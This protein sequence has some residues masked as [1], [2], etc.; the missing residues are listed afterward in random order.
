[1][2]S[3]L[4]SRRS[5]A[6]GAATWTRSR[7]CGT[8][9]CA[10]GNCRPA[11]RPYRRPWPSD[12]RT[13]FPAFPHEAV[14]DRPARDFPAPLEFL[15]EDLRIVVRHAED[16]GHLSGRASPEALKDRRDRRLGRVEGLRHEVR[17]DLPEHVLEYLPGL[18]SVH[19]G[20]H[21]APPDFA[22]SEPGDFTAF[23]FL[24]VLPKRL[25]RGPVVQRLRERVDIE[26][27]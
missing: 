15:E 14:S 1:M 5:C 20:G 4:V 24:A 25:F 27:D 13:S 12:S 22:R 18:P 7:F 21:A 2:R 19:P 8:I 17:V 6:N 3:R 11:R 10:N 26:A 9:W 16:R 23:T